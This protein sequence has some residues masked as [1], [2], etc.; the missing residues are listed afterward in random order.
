MRPPPDPVTTR[1]D[2]SAG[3][4]RRRPAVGRSVRSRQV[5]ADGRRY[6]DPVESVD[7]VVAGAGLAGLAAALRLSRAGLDVRV[8][9]A[10]DRPG[11][12]MATDRV[13][14][15]L[16]DRG[17]QLL[18]PAYPEVTGVLDVP[19]LRL[20]PFDRGVAVR[21]ADGAAGL[22]VLADPLR[23]PSRAIDTLRSPAGSPA[24]KLRFAA[25]GA[26]I[27]YGPVG[28]IKGG[29]DEP[30][31]DTLRRLHLAD[32]LGRTVLQPFL[33]GV[34]AQADLTTSRRV[35]ELF[36]RS[37][38]RGTPALPAAGIQAVPEQVAA[39]LP[40]GALR[41]GCEVTA[42]TGTRVETS[43]GPLAAHAVVVACDPV[44]ACRLTGLPEPV[45]RGLTT[46]YHLAEPAPTQL[47]LLHVDG[48]HTGPVVNT[49]VVSNVAPTYSTRGPLVAST[50][51][52]VPSESGITEA[53]A[54]AHAGRIF[55]VD[56]GG[57][58]HVS[59]VEIP[60]AL[61][62]MPAGTPLRKRTDLGGG[63]FVAGDHR[64]TPSIQGALVSGRRVADQVLAHLRAGD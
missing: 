24:Q 14:G 54:R 8:V 2:L 38:L 7:V 26:R 40:G 30:F 25:W 13:G 33:S 42:V 43:M 63:L 37:F 22:S 57:W 53:H 32:G 46:V 41:L 17:F 19:A 64:D 15:L 4:G 9:E 52:G 11:G 36:L 49:A 6:S 48:A 18:N 31:A 12:R 34:L 55:G 45:T 20:Q 50:V 1:I 28:V 61:P 39:A 16:L 5:S 27:G 56:P 35:V 59:T 62:A 47:K 3:G 60:Q 29:P 10:S 58:T 23:L 51:L 21:L 44:T